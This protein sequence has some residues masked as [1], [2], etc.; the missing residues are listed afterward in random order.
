MKLQLC[1]DPFNMNFI[2]RLGGQISEKEFVSIKNKI[3]KF[4]KTDWPKVDKIIPK[5]T[6][7]PWGEAEITLYL[8]SENFPV[9]G[10]HYPLMIRWNY[11]FDKFLLILFHELAHRNFRHGNVKWEEK[12][13]EPK[14]QAIAEKVFKELYGDTRL[15]KIK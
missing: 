8:A 2:M 10:R 6:N 9:G 15:K 1:P 11:A 3:L 7:I 4:M 12:T 5:I 14:A 13:E